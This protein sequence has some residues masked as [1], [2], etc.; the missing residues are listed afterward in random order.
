M[1]AENQME[2]KQIGVPNAGITKFKWKLSSYSSDF[3]KDNGIPP[4]NNS[5]ATCSTDSEKH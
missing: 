5:T 3:L 2:S 1:E 4:Y